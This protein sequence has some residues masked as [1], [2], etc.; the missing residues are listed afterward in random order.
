M[1]DTEQTNDKVLIGFLGDED[2]R[3]RLQERAQQEDRS[4]SSLLRRAAERYLS[5]AVDRAVLVPAP[6]FDKALVDAPA[7][8]A[9]K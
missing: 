9:V 4:M 5:T 6:L 8:Y 3:R 7:E 2:L 1:S